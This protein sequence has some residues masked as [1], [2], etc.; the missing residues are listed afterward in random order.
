MPQ[1][2]YK[3]CG[4]SHFNQQLNGC[5]QSHFG[6]DKHVRTHSFCRAYVTDNWLSTHDLELVRRMIGHRSMSSTQLY[7][8]ENTSLTLDELKAR[9]LLSD[10]SL[11][12]V[13]SEED[14]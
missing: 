2:P 14:V 10:K 13:S 9:N 4:R 3:P 12:E 5:L 1:N 7:V 6:G 11:K 8:S